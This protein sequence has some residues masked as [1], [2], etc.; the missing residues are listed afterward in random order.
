[1]NETNIAIVF[2]A[3]GEIIQ[4][5][6]VDIFVLRAENEH[7]KEQLKKKEERNG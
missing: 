7:L 6:R 3:L 4:K 2:D 1:M 5:L